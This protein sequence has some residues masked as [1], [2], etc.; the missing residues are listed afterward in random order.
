MLEIHHFHHGWK[1]CWRMQV[2]LQTR[3][4]TCQVP[5][6]GNALRHSSKKI[7]MMQDSV[8]CFPSVQNWV[9]S[10]PKH[11]LFPGNAEFLTSFR[12]CWPINWCTCHKNQGTHPVLCLKFVT[13]LERQLW[14]RL[15]TD[16]S[17][18]VEISA[19]TPF[20]TQKT[21]L[22]ANAQPFFLLMICTEPK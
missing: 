11:Q 21:T 2:T 5:G 16:T 4:R 6:S 17:W 8:A 10:L 19:E 12:R 18:D 15:Q 1:A 3:Y 22:K 20:F 7:E 9:L 13:P 14:E